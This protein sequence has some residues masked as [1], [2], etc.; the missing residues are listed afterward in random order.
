MNK[1]GKMKGTVLE[2]TGPADARKASI[3]SKSLIDAK[4]GDQKKDR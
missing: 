3:A 4:S 2:N 1:K